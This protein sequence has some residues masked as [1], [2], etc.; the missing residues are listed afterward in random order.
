LLCFPSEEQTGDVTNRGDP[1][2]SICNLFLPRNVSSIETK[3][4]HV[5]Y[6]ISE[7]SV[8]QI[9]VRADGPQK[10]D[11]NNVGDTGFYTHASSSQMSRAHIP[12][13]VKAIMKEL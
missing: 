5:G 2:I 9:W 7:G 4:Q 3:L 12:F 11:D 1:F 6:K 13:D 8:A 10:T